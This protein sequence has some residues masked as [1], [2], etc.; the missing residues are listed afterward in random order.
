MKSRFCAGQRITVSFD[1]REMPVPAKISFISDQAEYTPPII[2]SAQT[3]AKLVFMAEAV[4][5]A[6][7][8]ECLHPGQPVE[9][10]NGK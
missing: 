3:R 2:Y 6:R 9:V 10:R 8:A 4:P 5:D 7:F 1:G